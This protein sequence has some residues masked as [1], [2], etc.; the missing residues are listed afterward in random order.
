MNDLAG[1]TLFECCRHVDTPISLGVWL[2]YKYAHD[3]LARATINPRLYNDAETFFKDYACVNLLRKYEGL[4]TGIDTRSVALQAFDK[5]EEQCLRMNRELWSFTHTGHVGQVEPRIILKVQKLIA[6]VWGNPTFNEMFRHCGWGPGATATLKGARATTEGKMSELP[7]SVTPTALPYLR[8]VMKDDLSWCGHLL[9]CPVEGPVCL[10]PMCYDQ[11]DHSRLLTVPKDAKTDRVIAAEPTGNI[12]LQKGVGGY[13]RRRLRRY[14]INLEDQTRNQ[15]LA[16]TAGE[17]KLATLDLSAASDTISIGLCKAL[18]PPSMFKVLDDLRSPAFALDG[19]IVRFH[20]ISSMGNGFTFELETLLFWAAAKAVQEF[21]ECS[22]PIGVY[23]DDIIVPQPI[24]REVISVLQGFGFSINES[25]S[26]VDGRF[27]ESCGG[28]YF[29]G[30]DVTPYYQKHDMDNDLEIC[31]FH[32]R[33]FGLAYRRPYLNAEKCFGKVHSRMFSQLP[34]R[35]KKF[36]APEW[37]EGDGFFHVLHF[38]GRFSANRGYLIHY[39][40]A[41][42]A[43][44]VLADGGLYAYAMRKR[45]VTEWVLREGFPSLL[46]SI[47]VHSHPDDDLTELRAGLIGQLDELSDVWSR[48]YVSIR[49]K[50]PVKTYKHSK[51][52]VPLF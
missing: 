9:K 42:R 21:E 3:E 2:R 45:S 41:E 35:L 43:R 40:A 28:H 49:P 33:I 17:L 25:K 51:R 23:G 5:A 37:V 4:E 10:M 15:A 36:Q 19:K 7:M 6:K 16:A 48:G 27:F 26:F 38:N 39:M 29:D 11:T 34:D 1:N 13:L 12:F 32:N 22:G 44:E 8:Q 20:K 18:L 52:W 31:R 14:G 50:G 46:G 24:V 30:V 47:S